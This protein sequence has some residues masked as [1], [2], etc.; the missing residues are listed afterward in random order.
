MDPAA[1][2]YT[3]G[4]YSVLTGDHLREWMKPSIHLLTPPV[5]QKHPAASPV[6]SSK[7]F[8]ITNAS[9]TCQMKHPRRPPTGKRRG[10]VTLIQLCG[11]TDCWCQY[12]R[13]RWGWGWGGGLGR[14]GLANRDSAREEEFIFALP[15]Q[16]LS[17]AL[18]CGVQVV[19]SDAPQ[20]NTASIPQV[21]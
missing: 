12:C 16:K 10:L 7:G 11:K 4:C 8:G 21:G 6:V 18:V 17:K 20:I 5:W 13:E 15:P 9:D 2:C 1:S 3:T 19:L 14:A